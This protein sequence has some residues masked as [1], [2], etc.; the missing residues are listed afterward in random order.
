MTIG[1]H[2]EPQKLHPK[3]PH[4][5]D[6]ESVTIFSENGPHLQGEGGEVQLGKNLKEEQFAL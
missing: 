5:H 6:F 1:P 3:T 2:L 4:T